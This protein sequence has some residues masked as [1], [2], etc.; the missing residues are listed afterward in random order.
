MNRLYR[1]Q[2]YIYDLTRKHFLPGREVLL[3]AMAVP[4]RGRVLEAG[5]GTARNLILLARK[6]P[7]STFFG[8]DASTEML[9]VARR[10]IT[11]RGLHERIRIGPALAEEFDRQVIFGVEAPFDA[12]YFSYS[13]SMMPRW[14]QALDQVLA[15]IRCGGW[16]YI[17]DF[18]DMEGWP[19]CLRRSIQKLLRTYHTVYRPES[20]EYLRTLAENGK[21]VLTVKTLMRGY[22]HVAEFKTQS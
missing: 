11:R 16:L 5:C 7:D 21:G 8:F 12:A 20:L 10:K 22:A 18:C 13:L 19:G 6:Y 1:P 9:A 15:Q 4:A 3:R 2:K 17:A 14:R